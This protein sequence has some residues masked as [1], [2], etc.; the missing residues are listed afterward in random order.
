MFTAIRRVISDSEDVGKSH[1]K[2]KT[3]M[4]NDATNTDEPE[5]MEGVQQ[6][7]ATAVEVTGNKFSPESHVVEPDHTATSAPL[8]MVHS[9][10]NSESYASNSSLSDGSEHDSR[11]D[12]GDA[13]VPSVTNIQAKQAKT[14]EQIVPP[15][16]QR[17]DRNI[18][19]RMDSAA[20]GSS[21][22]SQRASS[23]TSSRDWG[24]FEDVHQSTDRLN[25]TGEKRDVKKAVPPSQAPD[26]APPE[27]TH[28]KFA[29]QQG[30]FV[31]F[32]LPI[33]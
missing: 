3:T 21:S 8:K 11:D 23:Q 4:E 19:N 29:V 14:K 12:E 2:A 5:P 10:G 28:G 32:S 9:T 18:L 22:G 6:T 17:V 16:L 7:G 27:T 31:S 15:G 24:W 20:D 1:K 25:N 13:L 33:A 26:I 30:L